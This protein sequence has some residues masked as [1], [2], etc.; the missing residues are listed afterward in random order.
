[1]ITD[2]LPSFVYYST[3]GN[4]DSE[5][6]LPRVIEDMKRTD[7]TGKAEAR[8]RT[9]RVLFDFVKL[10]PEEI[11]ELGKDW[12]EAQGKMP[13]AE[14]KKID[15]KKKQRSISSSRRARI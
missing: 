15:D 8:A 2:C 7:L 3:Y 12:N 6:Y 10:K 13:E 4:L 5:I 9:L 1:M 14:F 11:L